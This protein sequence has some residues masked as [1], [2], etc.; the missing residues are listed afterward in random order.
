[1]PKPIADEIN[2]LPRRVRNYIHW[3]ETESD[4]AGTIRDNFRLREENAAL[5]QECERLSGRKEP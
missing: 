4:P 2:D 5:R 1:M 3:L